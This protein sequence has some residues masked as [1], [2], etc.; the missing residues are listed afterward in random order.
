MDVEVK[1]QCFRAAVAALANDEGLAAVTRLKSLPIEKA[2]AEVSLRS[3]LTLRPESPLEKQ[4]FAEVFSRYGEPDYWPLLLRGHAMQVAQQKTFMKLNAGETRIKSTLS[5]H[6]KSTPT[7]AHWK[8]LRRIL[9]PGLKVGTN[10]GTFLEGELVVEP[11]CVVGITTI[12]RDC[13]G[14]MVALGLYNFLTDELDA[15]KQHA[16]MIH[17]FSQGTR[18]RIKEPYYKFALHGNLQLRVDVPTDLEVV[19]DEASGPEDWK[20]RGNSHFVHGFWA[21]ADEAYSCGIRMLA[22]G[23][24]PLLPVLLGNRAECRL[25]MQRPA[26]ALEDV[27]AALTMDPSDA[28]REKLIARQAKALLSLRRWGE[29]I[30]L[31]ESTG[32]FPWLLTKAR[33]HVREA[34]GQYDW[35]Q[36]APVFLATQMGERPKDPDFLSDMAEY[37]G[38]VDVAFIPGKGRGIVTTK[39]VAAGDL[40]C[41]CRAVVVGSAQENTVG[42]SFT[43][44]KVFDNMS[45][46]AAKAALLR[47][48]VQCPEKLAQLYALYDA[49]DDSLR[50]PLFDDGEHAV[51]PRT[52][53]AKMDIDMERL[54]RIVDQNCFG[55]RG[56]ALYLLASFFNHSP[57]PTAAH[58]VAG[59]YMF[60]RA[61][62]DMPPGAEVTI[63]YLLG[64]LAPDERDQR[65][66][67]HGAAL[68]ME[69]DA[70][71]RLDPTNRVTAILAN[72]GSIDEFLALTH[73]PANKKKI[74][75]A[76]ALLESEP[77][78]PRLQRYYNKML[79]FAQDDRDACYWV[80]RAIDCNPNC[81]PIS[82]FSL[83]LT[84][85]RITRN[86]ALA[87]RKCEALLGQGS[88][89]AARAYVD[90]V[91]I[92]RG[93]SQ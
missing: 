42:H 54:S 10:Q 38:S 75:A 79:D 44:T 37:R 19:E 16:A 65:L 22:G 6:M 4:L 40:L 83:T 80:Q 67:K 30:A 9:V 50:L 52:P 32:L 26:R 60:V 20:A 25:R 7:I 15:D 31:L 90:R 17:R 89:P 51:N 91:A 5:S 85:S 28:V 68:A 11:Y 14:N 24:L 49:T 93:S 21:A 77:M 63:S 82:L 88:W 58:L 13:D 66:R 71:A 78:H 41:V 23:S 70:D 43:R 3:G 35:P 73:S 27:L 81:D 8:S 84:L 76:R 87:R 39:G 36:L 47:L 72:L 29:A 57:A 18:V 55:H 48:S 62:Q 1:Q 86:E 56:T 45:Q 74:R 53:N 2:A 92:R 64:T 61:Q 12:L 46:V 69:R 34:D 59:D 33:R